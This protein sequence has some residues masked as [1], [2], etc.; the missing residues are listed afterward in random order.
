M[1]ETRQ[2]WSCVWLVWLGSL[3]NVRRQPIKVFRSLFAKRPSRLAAISYQDLSAAL[4]AK[5]PEFRIPFEQLR[6][7]YGGDKPGQH[8]VFGDI[9]SPFLEEHL[10]NREDREVLT[11]IFL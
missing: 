5:V 11:R 8:I 9:V 2:R 4:L 10:K 6:R 3:S 1:R 7:T